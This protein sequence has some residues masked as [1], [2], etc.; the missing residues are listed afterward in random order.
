MCKCLLAARYHRNAIGI[1][2]DAGLLAALAVAKQLVP[3][4]MTGLVVPVVDDDVVSH[5]EVVLLRL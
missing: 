1:Y 4:P 3:G 5:P 2:T